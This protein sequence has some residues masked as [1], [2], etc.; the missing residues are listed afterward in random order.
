MIYQ[1]P[2]VEEIVV[3]FDYSLLKNVLSLLTILFIE[4]KNVQDFVCF[5]LVAAVW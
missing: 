1:L 2:T 4:K 3:V 5:E